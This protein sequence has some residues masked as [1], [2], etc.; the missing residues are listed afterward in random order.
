MAEHLTNIIVLFG[1]LLLSGSMLSDHSSH[2]FNGNKEPVIQYTTDKD[3]DVTVYLV[4]NSNNIPLYY[5]TRLQ[6]PVCM[7]NLCNPIDIEIQW[8]LLGDFKEYVENPDDPVTKFDHQP[9]NEDDHQKLKSILANTQSLLQDYR[10]EDLVDTSV[11]I[12]SEE[13]DATTGATNKTF[14]KD[15][16]P[17]AIYTCYTLWTFVNGDLREQIFQHTM[18][19]LDDSVLLS[20]IS[21]GRKNYLDFILQ[22]DSLQF[23]EQV[24]RAVSGLIWGEDPL[25]STKAILAVNSSFWH[26][27]SIHSMVSQNFLKMSIPV[28]N[29]LIHELSKAELNQVTLVVLVDLLPEVG[30]RHRPR[31]YTILLSNAHLIDTSIKDNLLEI[32]QSSK[33]SLSAKEYEL[34]NKLDIHF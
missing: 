30:E 31:I 23:S 29:A 32:F 11:Q 4:R 20:M 16:V 10:M 1:M 12:Y 26:S 8:D 18:S 17:G 13:L 15:I 25:V 2:K 6:S 27:D 33:F 5:T 22:N 34:M 14:E 9:F 3:V 28:Q 24:N 19:I 7:E 21:N